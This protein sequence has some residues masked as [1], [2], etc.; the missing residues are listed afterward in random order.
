MQVL[1][2]RIQ[3]SGSISFADYMQ[4]ALYEP[5]L[6]YYVSGNPVFGAGGDFVTAPG[7]GKL[8][9]QSLAGQCH[10]VL[11]HLHSQGNRAEASS[12]QHEPPLAVV[13][14]GAGSGAL[15]ADVIP[16][17]AELGNLDDLPRV[18]YHI[19]ETSGMLRQQQK[20]AINKLPQQLSRTVQWH[21][22]LPEGLSGVVIANE[23]LDAM[24]VERLR[25]NDGFIEQLRL[26]EDETSGGFTESYRK[27]DQGEL[28]DSI[29]ALLGEL[30][31]AL[32]DGYQF[33]YNTYLPGWMMAVYAM[34]EAG[35]LFV[36]DYGYP[37]PE[38]FLPERFEGTLMCYYRQH[39]HSDPYFLPGAQDLTAH[40]DFTA[41]AEAAVAAGFSLNGYTSQS[42]FLQANDLLEHAARL[43]EAEGTTEMETLKL[44]QEVKTLCMPGSMGERFQVMGLGKQIDFAMK[45]FANL[46]MSHRL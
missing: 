19:I 32:P 36:V 10:E 20:E 23:V 5:G 14:F 34:L 25:V 1:H 12:Q 13:E 44:S 8:F 22:T 37:R 42:A 38:Y 33:E 30:P 46:E 15:A 31:Q 6:G 39:A 26:S 28:V 18:A 21:D 9:A 7:L 29:H 16:R 17:L 35:A 2:E 27:L 45:G 4:A 41:V 3:T 43:T 40:V 11:S 24:P